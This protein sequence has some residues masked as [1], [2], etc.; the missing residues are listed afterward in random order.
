MAYTK[1]K[2]NNAP[3]PFSF[4]RKLKDILSY[5][6]RMAKKMERYNI[7]ISDLIAVKNEPNV[8]GADDDYFRNFQRK[9]TR[10]IFF[11]IYLPII[12]SFLTTLGV[13]YYRKESYKT[14]YAQITAPVE[15]VKF[16][17]KIAAYFK[18]GVFII[19]DQ[20]VSTMELIPLF[21]FYSLAL[22]GSVVVSKNPVFQK[23]DELRRRLEALGH[24]DIEGK[25]WKVVWTPEAM[26]I[27]AFGQ[28]PYKL[29][30]NQNF[31]AT[32]NFHHGTPKQSKKDMNKF[33]VQKKHELS[34]NMI[35]KLPVGD[36]DE[37]S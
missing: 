24:V 28:D 2:Q 14:Y 37:R 4:K 9:N 25:P 32:M 26:L 10:I 36:T 34:N 3:P 7:G 8:N 5:P 13:A 11:M 18:K 30:Q 6:F 22:I 17:R 16:T 20:P 12:L 33:V 29:S 27:V 19:K 1:P 21:A 23:E 35:F 31:W 15:E